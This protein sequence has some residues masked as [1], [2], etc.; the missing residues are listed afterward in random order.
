MVGILFSLLTPHF[1]L[2]SRSMLN[3]SA[4]FVQQAV[5]FGIGAHADAQAVA[6]LSVIHV[7]DEDFAVFEG[8]EERLDRPI[9]PSRP[10]KISLAGQNSETQGAQ[11]FREPI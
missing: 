11:S 1:S 4:Q 8:I 9:L 3:H 5:D 7:A 10:D 6:M 2:L